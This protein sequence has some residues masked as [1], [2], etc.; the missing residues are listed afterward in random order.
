VLRVTV[1]DRLIFTQNRLI[2]S[3]TASG[4]SVYT[5]DVHPTR[6]E[7]CLNRRVITNDASDS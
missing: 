7:L 4:Q 3:K 6:V 2:T 1:Y 5:A